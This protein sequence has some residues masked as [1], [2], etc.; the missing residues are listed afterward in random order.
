MAKARLGLV[1][2]LLLFVGQE[3]IGLELRWVE[4]ETWYLLPAQALVREGRLRIP[5]FNTPER[6]L[7]ATPPLLA[8]LEAASWSVHDLTIVQARSL[9]LLFGCGTILLT[10]LVGERLIDQR[11][12]LLGALLAAMDNSL[13]LASRTVRPEI[14][15]AFFTLLALWLLLRSIQDGK[16]WL[17]ALAGIGVGAGM[18]SHPNGAVAAL[19]G[20]LLILLFEG[21]RAFRQ[22][23]L[24]VFAVA[25]AVAFLPYLIWVLVMDARTGGESLSALGRIQVSANESILQRIVHSVRGEW[26]SRYLGFLAYPYRVHVGLLV[27]GSIIVAMVWGNHKS[28]FLAGCVLLYPLY[29]CTVNN[30]NKSPRY[31]AVA[32]PFV[33][34]LWAQGI[35]FIWDKQLRGPANLVGWARPAT[36]RVIAV[37]LFVLAGVSQLGGNI[38][39]LWQSRQANVSSVCREIDALIPRDSTIYGGMAFWMGLHDHLYVPYQRMPWPQ[40]IDEFH[41]TIVI[42]DDRVMVHGS[43]PGEWDS[44]RC[45]LSEYLEIHGRLLGSVPNSFYGDLKVYEV[46]HAGTHNG[47]QKLQSTRDELGR[48]P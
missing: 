2:V 45:E 15:V 7:Y 37:A 3:V 16:L 25:S 22:P 47:D 8:I 19:C 30:F 6:R 29:W 23:R 34:L 18:S 31:L 40:A 1:A 4:D 21:R 38:L 33:A 41:P 5:V 26:E 27:L 44:L 14:L 39:Y 20:V 28:R 46:S 13:F 32:M 17:A 10:F 24:Y 36:L 9:T 11:V 12:G 48:A 42:M 35:V 43:E